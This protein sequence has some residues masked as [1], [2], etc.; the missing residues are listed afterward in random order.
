MYVG[1]DIQP[2]STSS[3]HRRLEIR[4]ITPRITVN[5]AQATVRVLTCVVANPHLGLGLQ[6]DTQPC[7]AVAEFTA[8]TLD[9]GFPATEIVYQ[10]T[11]TRTG[12]VRIEGA[13]VSY[14]DGVRTGVQHAGSGTVLRIRTG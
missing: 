2:K 11:A 14:R 6:A 12:E 5:T 8:G 3:G 4:R 9:L 1:A 13:D 10:V 7:R